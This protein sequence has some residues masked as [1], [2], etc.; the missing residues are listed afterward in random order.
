MDRKSTNIKD[1]FNPELFLKYLDDR[2]GVE[3]LDFLKELS[4]ISE[5]L[6]FSGII[7]NFFINTYGPARDLD[8]VVDGNKNSVGIFLDKFLSVRNSFGG[9]KITVGSVK[10]DIWHIEDTWAYSNSKVDFE[11]FQDYNL[12]NTAFFNFSSVVFDFNNSEFIPSTSFNHFLDTKELDMVLEDNPMPQLCI[13]NT[14][15]YMT[16][17][18]LNVSFKLKNYCLQYFDKFSEEDFNEVQVKHFNEVKYD[19]PFLKTYMYI[20]KKEVMKN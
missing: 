16:K 19:Y 18:N 8:L 2:L 7:R 3:I 13:V 5:V 14:I 9:Y 17:F 12:P 10:V 4:K 1:K 6:I 20:F 15:Y 11:L